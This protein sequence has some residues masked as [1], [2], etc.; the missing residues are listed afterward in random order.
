MTHPLL[1]IKNLS[2]EFKGFVPEVYDFIPS[3]D[4]VFTSRYLGTLE[5]F[6]FK[7]PVFVVYNNLIK[8]DCFILSPFIDFIIL[9]NT[10]DQLANR[11]LEY[12]NNSNLMN[13]KNDKAFDWVKNQTWEKMTNQYLSL[14]SKA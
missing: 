3:T 11:F 2:V 1:Q 12:V 4:L 7:K 14:W 13:K 10:E 9:E 6:V 5:S 8:K